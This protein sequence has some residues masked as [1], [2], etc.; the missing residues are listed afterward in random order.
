MSAFSDRVGDDTVCDM[1]IEES[2]PFFG[3][4]ITLI[5]D[6]LNLRAV[7]VIPVE[8]TIGKLNKSLELEEEI[9]AKGIF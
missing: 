5:F 9:W 8:M 1:V 7:W 4:I 6:M 3:E 2:N